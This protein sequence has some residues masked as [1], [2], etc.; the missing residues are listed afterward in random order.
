MV[1]INGVLSFITDITLEYKQILTTNKNQVA[2][3]SEFIIIVTCLIGQIFLREIKIGLVTC[4]KL[5]KNS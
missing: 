4:S 2:S 1:K 5:N 3:L